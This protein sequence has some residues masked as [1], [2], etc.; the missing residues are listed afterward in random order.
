MAKARPGSP[1]VN[2]RT[3]QTSKAV[4]RKRPKAD[5]GLDMVATPLIITSPVHT[6]HF[7]ISHVSLYNMSHSK[8]RLISCWQWD[9]I[10]KL[11]MWTLGC[12]IFRRSL[13]CDKITDPFGP[14]SV[15]PI[16]GFPNAS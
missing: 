5:R 10:L 8:S 14:L 2:K 15:H 12:G 1:R 7:T 16:A 11:K 3:V 4:L 13:S 9:E 6:F